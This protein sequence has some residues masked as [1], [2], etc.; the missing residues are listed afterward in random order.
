MAGT[1]DILE[2]NTFLVSDERG[3]V[4]G[5]PV[6]AHGLFDRDTRFL[7]RWV[8]TLDGQR[9]APLSVDRT[10]YYAA[11]FFLAPGVASTYINAKIAVIRRRT[12]LDGFHEV[13]SVT[14]HDATPVTLQLMLTADADFADLFEVK[15]AT[16]QQKPG[17]HY[18][19]TEEDR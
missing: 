5:S 2:G 10:R 17:R 6:E 4:D 11:Q 14:N 1:V 15:D 13:I 7:S 16:V 8:L 3:D 9:L 12:V 19:R 18:R